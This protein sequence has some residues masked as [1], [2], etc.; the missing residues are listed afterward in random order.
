MENSLHS[1]L[2]SITFV[3]ATE[4]SFPSFSAALE[5][6][7]PLEFAVWPRNHAC[8]FAEGCLVGIP[9]Q[10]SHSGTVAEKREMAFPENK[11]HL[12]AGKLFE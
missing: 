10:T 12:V 6:F 5:S 1:T 2:N 8:V 7:S 4:T 11:I 3:N 9:F